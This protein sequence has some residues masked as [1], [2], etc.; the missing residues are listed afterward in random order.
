[1][2]PY[3][4]HRPESLDD[5]GNALAQEGARALAGGTDLVP[6]LREGRRS[7]HHLVD[8]KG[9]AEC[10][11]IARTDGGQLTLGAALPVSTIARLPEINAQHHAIADATRMIGSVQ[12]Q[13]RATL[14]GNIC[15]GAPSA[16]AVPALMACGTLAQIFG[17]AD[18]NAVPLEDLLA[19]PGRVNLNQG[20]FL[21]SLTVDAPADRFASAYLRFTPRREMDIAVA[22]VAVRLVLDAQGKIADARIA[23]ASVA[24]TVVRAGTAERALAGA[25]LT[26]AA[27]AAAAD[28]AAGD[29]SPISD[30]RGSADYRRALVATLCRRALE[31]CRERMPAE[32]SA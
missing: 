28:A 19:G 12:V 20:E 11:A 13:N 23:L 22:G 26:D 29:A 31:R 18:G 8:L 3:T 6:Q 21:V 14:G 4:Y 2:T 15:N 24:P 27:I 1:M 9:V 7:A 16:D 30:T 5:A 17:R 10:T 25:E 32:V